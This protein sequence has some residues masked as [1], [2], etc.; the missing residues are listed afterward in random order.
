MMTVEGLF[1]A[2]YELFTVS[3]VDWH[4]AALKARLRDDPRFWDEVDLLLDAR[5]E[6]MKTER[7]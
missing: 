1:G 7:V 2:R 3:N 4:L 6:L 5:I